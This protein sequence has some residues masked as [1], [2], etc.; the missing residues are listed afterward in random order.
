[1]VRSTPW[2]MDY[3]V[4]LKVPIRDAMPLIIML[5]NIICVTHTK[6]YMQFTTLRKVTVTL[7]EAHMSV[8]SKRK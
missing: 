5:Q 6:C 8:N 3:N 2:P 1:M 4:L 7:R